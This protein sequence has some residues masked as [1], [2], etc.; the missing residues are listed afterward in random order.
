MTDKYES[1]TW[2]YLPTNAMVAVSKDLLLLLVNLI[3][4]LIDLSPL[5]KEGGERSRMLN[6][7]VKNSIIICSIDNNGIC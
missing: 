1:F 2:V 6:F 4:F 7:L 3:H 5:F